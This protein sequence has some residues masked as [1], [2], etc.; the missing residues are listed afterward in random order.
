[1]TRMDSNLVNL[2]MSLAS[3]QNIL[4]GSETYATAKSLQ[5]FQVFGLKTKL[6][7]PKA[8][9]ISSLPGSKLI[10]DLDQLHRVLPMDCLSICDA[11]VSA[12]QRKFVGL[13]E[14]AVA[15]EVTGIEVFSTPTLMLMKKWHR[16]MEAVS[17][18]D[19]SKEWIQC[20]DLKN[21]FPKHF[22]VEHSDDLFKKL[23]N[24]P[25]NR[26]SIHALDLAARGCIGD[27]TM[28]VVAEKLFGTDPNV[29]LIDPSHLGII[30]N[31][32]ITVNTD[33]IT[34]FLRANSCDVV[35]IPV[36]CNRNHWCSIM[37][38][39]SS[40]EVHIY[41][42]M[43]SKYVTFVRAAAQK[44]IHLLR[45][46]ADEPS[47]SVHLYSSDVGVQY[48]SY[49]CDIY[50]LLS[51]EHFTGAP[52]LGRGD[53]KM[54]QCLRYRTYACATARNSEEHIK[55]FIMHWERSRHYK[56]VKKFKSD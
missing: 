1:M 27:D 5:Q 6:K 8:H 48:D 38:R 20:I 21:D 4:T 46:T 26:E 39:S 23:E 15:V 7:P 25:L 19:K 11:K 12:L 47:Y 22:E 56:R 52:Q 53:K 2:N 51:F 17:R 40:R 31:G 44:L 34:A 35:L 18:I 30:L 54:L 37:V 13:A 9:T 16:V 45:K 43:S 14:K 49:N 42:P 3:V 29:T 55:T 33:N 50:V 28:C 32:E 36:N 41:D 10:I 24:I